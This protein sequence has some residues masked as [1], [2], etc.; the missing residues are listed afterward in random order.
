MS[1]VLVSIATHATG[2]CMGA[3][4]LHGPELGLPCTGYSGIACTGRWAAG[5]FVYTVYKTW[6]VGVCIDIQLYM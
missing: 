3:L 1:R 5:L 4:Q 6:C 2:T